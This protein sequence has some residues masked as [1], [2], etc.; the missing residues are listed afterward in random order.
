METEYGGK[1][2]IIQKRSDG[3]EPDASEQAMLT[4]MYGKR[5]LAFEAY[6]VADEDGNIYPETPFVNPEKD[7]IEERANGYTENDL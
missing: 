3:H 1:S 7:R 4:R 2:G 5:D 6:K